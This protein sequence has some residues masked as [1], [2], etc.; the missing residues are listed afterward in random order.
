[1]LRV[2]VSERGFLVDVNL[3]WFGLATRVLGRRN[4]HISIDLCGIRPES[5]VGFS[6]ERDSALILRL[7]SQMVEDFAAFGLLE[8][9]CERGD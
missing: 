9:L 6:T 1:M 3:D 7:F 4:T 2:Q 8:T 5:V